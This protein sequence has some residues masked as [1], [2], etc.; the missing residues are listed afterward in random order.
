MGP[1]MP[2]MRVFRREFE[3]KIVVIEFIK[4]QFYVKNKKK[5]E[6]GTKNV[7]FQCFLSF[8]LKKYF[9]N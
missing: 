6:F 5:K 4:M 3:N 1:K 2:Y 9:Y 8:N 7:L